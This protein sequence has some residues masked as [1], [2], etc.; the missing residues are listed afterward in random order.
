MTWF[1][2]TNGK[3]LSLNEKYSQRNKQKKNLHDQFSYYS[4]K[5]RD[6]SGKGVASN[7]R[8]IERKN[9][10]ANSTD[11]LRKN[12]GQGW[13][14][15]LTLLISVILEKHPGLLYVL[16]LNHMIGTCAR[17]GLYFLVI[18]LSGK[19]IEFLIGFAPLLFFSRLYYTVSMYY[20]LF[21]FEQK[22]VSFR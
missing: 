6:W 17:G 12:T 3:P 2:N 1:K 5:G 9:Q 18:V 13:T 8:L 16:S 4:R 20:L 7:N 15:N 11:T 22:S 10:A 14:L 19:D 21:Y